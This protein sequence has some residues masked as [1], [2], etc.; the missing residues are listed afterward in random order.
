[1]TKEELIQLALEEGIIQD[2]K[3]ADLYDDDDSSEE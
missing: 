2:L 3:E 1:M